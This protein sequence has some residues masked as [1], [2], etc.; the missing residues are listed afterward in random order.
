[1]IERLLEEGFTS[2]DVAAALLHQLQSGEGAP[3]KQT[4][5]EEEYPQ[6]ESRGYREDRPRDDR[7]ERYSDRREERPRFE[8]QRE[9]RRDERPRREQREFPPRKTVAMSPRPVIAK[10]ASAPSAPVPPAPATPPTATPPEPKVESQKTYSDEEI[11]A[12]VKQPESAKKVETKSAPKPKLSRRTPENQTRLWMNVGEEM[13]VVPIDVV[14]TIAGETGLPGKIVGTVD[15]RERHLF[16]DVATEH[17]NSVLSKLKRSQ[18][19]GH[20]LKVKI[21]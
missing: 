19:K 18:I 7:R 13:G 8:R 2:T 10:P 1:M 17:V 11:L 14:N 9:D 15:V 16:V 12:S 4:A 5:R 20:N 21:A 6:R 3:A